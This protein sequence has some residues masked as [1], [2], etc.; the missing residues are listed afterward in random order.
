ME[1][2]KSY[3]R[4]RVLIFSKKL[5]VWCALTWA[6]RN[7]WPCLPLFPVSWDVILHLHSLK[8]ARSQ[9]GRL[10]TAITMWHVPLPTWHFILTQKSKL[11]LNICSCWNA[12]LLSCVKR[13]VTCNMWMKLERSCFARRGR[14]WRD[15]P[16]HRMHCCSTQSE[17]HI[18]QEYDAPVSRLNNMHILQ[19]VGAGLLMRTAIHG[20][21]CGTC[22]L[23]SP[24]PAV[25]KSNVAARFKL[26]VAQGVHAERQ[27]GRSLNSAVVTLRSRLGIKCMCSGV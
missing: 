21:L 26:D 20:F 5:G 25:N 19:K 27:G 11:V 6:G 12:S 18:R 10:G 22:Y 17:L 23:W 14:Q 15:F 16:Q 4:F 1:R 9:H 3:R 13:P 24:R 7:P 8:E 2:K